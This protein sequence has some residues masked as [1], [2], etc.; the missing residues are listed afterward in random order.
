[1]KYSFQHRAMNLKKQ[2]IKKKKKKKGRS[3]TMFRPKE[4][5]LSIFLVHLS[6]T[7]VSLAK[8]TIGG[9]RCGGKIFRKIIPRRV[10]NDI[11]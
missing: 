4:D 1:M 6:M 5:E 3:G 10:S 11:H 7:E 2:K 9:C 8:C